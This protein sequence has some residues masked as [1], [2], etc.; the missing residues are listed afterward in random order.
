[1]S[2][3]VLIAS[4]EYLPGLQKRD[5]L[6]GA[7]AFTD[8]DALRALV[9]IARRRPGVVAIEREFATT[10]RGA[11]LIKR[12]KADPALAACDVRVITYDSDKLPVSPE[13]AREEAAILA[14]SAPDPAVVKAVPPTVATLDQRGTRRV[15]RSK[16]AE[17]VGV[18][19]DGYTASLV[20]LSVIGA[21]VLSPTILKPNRHVRF[22]LASEKQPMRYRAV[23]IWASFEIPKDAAVYRA[24]LELLDASQELVTSFIEAN[25]K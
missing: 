6:G 17:G 15:L 5:D 11:S 2:A 7:I 3:T 10:R 1:V 4:A 12:I 21:Q 18:Q 20:D 14:A 19:I 16:I 8:K 9:A 22:T 23:V 24:G 25:K 13:A